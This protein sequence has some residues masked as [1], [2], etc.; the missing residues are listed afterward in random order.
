MRR[1]LA[2][3]CVLTAA[4]AGC[5][6]AHPS[7]PTRVEALHVTRTI[8]C[9]GWFEVTGTS[10]AAH[11]SFTGPV[12][13]VAIRTLSDNGESATDDVTFPVSPGQTQRIVHVG[14]VMRVVVATQATVRDGSTAQATCA[15][16]VPH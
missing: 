16:S 10:L 9:S 1:S 14:G 12:R 15:L 7:V 3:T 6:S 2:L 11:L 13:T 5:G 4:A 8:G